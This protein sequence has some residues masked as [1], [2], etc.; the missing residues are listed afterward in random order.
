M[1]DINRVLQK[2]TELPD[3]RIVYTGDVFVMF[4]NG[5]VSIPYQAKPSPQEMTLLLDVVKDAQ[6]RYKPTACIREQAEL[7]AWCVSDL[8]NHAV[9]V[10]KE[11]ILKWQHPLRRKRKLNRFF[12]RIEK[13]YGLSEDMKEFALESARFYKSN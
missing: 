2:M 10:S 8:T 6:Y 12:R 11:D 13:R 1:I 3:E 7:I 4:E 9:I 5:D